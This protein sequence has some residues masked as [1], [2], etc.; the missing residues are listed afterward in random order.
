M[1][2]T[3]SNGCRS[4]NFCLDGVEIITINSLIKNNLGITFDKFIDKLSTKDAI[5]KVVNFV[6]EQTG[7]EKFGEYLGSILELDAF[8][9]NE[10]RHMNNII[11]KSFFKAGKSGK[12]IYY[13]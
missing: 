12:G 10:D 4:M 2:S 13:K 6:K 9:L 1:K 7:L 5:E 11:L 3:K 8:I